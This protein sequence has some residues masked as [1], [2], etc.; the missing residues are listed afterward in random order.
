MSNIDDILYDCL[1]QGASIKLSGKELV[2]EGREYVVYEY[3]KYARKSNVLYRGEN[4][5]TA[6]AKLL[7]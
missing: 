5:K 2:N 3:K 4:L 1:K 6:L 7:R